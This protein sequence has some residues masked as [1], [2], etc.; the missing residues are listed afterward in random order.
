MKKQLHIKTYGCQMNVYD[1]N[2][3]TDVLLPLG[4]EL[5]D[6]PQ[7]ADFVIFNTCHIRE[8]AS[9]K[10]YSDLGRVKPFKEEKIAQGQDMLIAVAGCT[11]QAE[12]SEVLR[13]APYVDMVFGPQAY[14]DLPEMLAR[15][16]REKEKRTTLSSKGIGILNVE[17][18][19]VSK[20][21]SLPE[22]TAIEGPS[23]FLSIQ[24]GCDKFCHFCVVPYTRGA[25]YS[26]PVADVLK[27]ARRLVSLGVKEIT[28]LGQNVNAYH[29]DSLKSASEEW[30]LG[31]LLLELAEVEGLEIL[32]YMT[33]HPRDVDAELI[34]AHRSIP[35]LAPMLHLPVQ[36]GSD[37][38][39]KAMNRKHTRAFYLDIIEKFRTA[40]PDIAFSSDFIV[41]YPGEEER[42]HQETLELVRAITYAQAY[43]FKYS[44]RPGTPASALETQVPEEVK[45]ERLQELQAVLIQ[46]Q[47]SFNAACVGREM[48]I[49]FERPGRHEGQLIGHSPYMQSVHVKAPARLMGQVLP[50][51]IVE[52]GNNSLTGEVI[53]GEN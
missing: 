23:A 44:R 48:K 20:F 52:C 38:I 32:R 42:D 5:T 8:K 16:W 24:E 21:D 35:Q 46:D 17:F 13:R 4:F 49:L 3:M 53:T 15:A 30:G 37:R 47:K 14:Q 41:G 27:E 33:S 6:S 45:D 50:V 1:S 36:S 26:R 28:L 7:G 12:G 11:A 19:E 34:E 2:R 18:P 43:S 29:G 39:L 25:E 40:R 9:E 10:L 31:R 22:V 51:K